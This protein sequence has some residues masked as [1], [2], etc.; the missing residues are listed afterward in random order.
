MILIG[1]SGHAF[2]VAEAARSTGQPLT[3]YCDREKKLL[4]PYDLPYLG[5]EGGEAAGHHLAYTAFFVSIGHNR[6]R[7]AVTL[8]LLTSKFTNHRA[9]LHVSSTVA[10]SAVLGKGVLVAPQAVIN[11]L[12]TIG[13]G[14]II[15]TAAIVEHES[16]VGEFA[17]IAPGVTLTGNVTVGRGAFIGAGTT[18]LPGLKIG[19]YAVV[20]AGAVVLRD[21]MP[22]EKVAGVPARKME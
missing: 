12:A 21:V 19:E 14:A 8:K 18:V 4:D 11:P 22:H 7:E 10:D 3:G 6:I 9:V 2:V 1:Y 16:K 5:P 15:N 13:Q 20:G 17:H